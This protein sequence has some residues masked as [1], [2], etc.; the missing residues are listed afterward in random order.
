MQPALDE[1]A[2]LRA[3]E[4]R[5]RRRCGGDGDGG[6]VGGGGGGSEVDASELGGLSLSEAQDEEEELDLT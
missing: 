6:R 1:L 2:R 3:L 4:R 5:R